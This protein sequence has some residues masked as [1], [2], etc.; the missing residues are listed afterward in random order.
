MMV[1]I[2]MDYTITRQKRLILKHVI[3]IHVCGYGICHSLV[4]LPVH[5]TIVNVPLPRN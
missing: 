4:E 3:P 2:S 5:L 1:R